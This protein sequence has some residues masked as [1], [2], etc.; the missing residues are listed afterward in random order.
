MKGVVAA[1]G[2]DDEAEVAGRIGDGES[3]VT[4]ST[5]V[6]AAEVAI[7]VAD[8]GTTG[9]GE[10]VVIA[11]ALVV[12]STGG[13]SEVLAAAVVG[14]GAAVVGGEAAVVG[15]GA[16]D[17][18]VGN[19]KLVGGGADVVGTIGDDIVAEALVS[20]PVVNCVVLVVVSRP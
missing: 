17:V 13:V 14:G 15:G 6:A 1:E 4:A 10:D 19:P 5:V 8:V 2:I 12:D 20:M 7:E 11:A 3:V 16:A 9:D 18:V